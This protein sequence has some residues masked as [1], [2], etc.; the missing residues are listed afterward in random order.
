MEVTRLE[1]VTRVYCDV[2]FEEI[3]NRTRR[4]Y[5][6]TKGEPVT[7]CDNGQQF[8]GDVTCDV[9]FLTM[10]SYLSGDKDFN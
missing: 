10:R 3:T 4:I 9:K 6:D 1:Q 8:K 5:V 2:C 7:I